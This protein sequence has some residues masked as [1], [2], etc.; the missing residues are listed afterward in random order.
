MMESTLSC[1]STIPWKEVSSEASVP[2]LM[3]PVSSIGNRPLG[4]T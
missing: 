3:N 1:F 2:Q 4:I